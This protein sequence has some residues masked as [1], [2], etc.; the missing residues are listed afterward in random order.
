[1][2]KSRIT[3]RMEVLTKEHLTKDTLEEQL[4]I[5]REVR[6]YLL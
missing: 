2:I 6:D 5:E 4:E 1:M 3:N